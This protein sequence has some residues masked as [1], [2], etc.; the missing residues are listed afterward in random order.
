MVSNDPA[1]LRTAQEVARQLAV[2]VA[3]VYAAAASGRLPCVKLWKGRRRALVRF[4]QSDVDALI[5]DGAAP[6]GACNGPL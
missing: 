1:P 2:K 4:R 3:T 5:C 6:R